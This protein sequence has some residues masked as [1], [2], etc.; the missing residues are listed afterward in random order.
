MRKYLCVIFVFQFSEGL[1]QKSILI[2]FN[3]SKYIRETSFVIR[4]KYGQ[5]VFSYLKLITLIMC[6]FENCTAFVTVVCFSRAHTACERLVCEAG[7]SCG[8]FSVSSLSLVILLGASHSKILRASCAL[9][10]QANVS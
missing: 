1:A 7:E 10:K 3:H 4:G 9:G 5:C 6:S 8:E 2:N